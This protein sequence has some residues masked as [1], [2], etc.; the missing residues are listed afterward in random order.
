M[1]M[2]LRMRIVNAMVYLVLNHAFVPRH[3][4]GFEDRP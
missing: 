1:T 3:E 2:K 4:D